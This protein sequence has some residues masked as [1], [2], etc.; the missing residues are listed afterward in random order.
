MSCRTSAEYFM[1]YL[2]HLSPV[3]LYDF[4]VFKIAGHIVPFVGVFDMVV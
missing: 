3:L 2:R 1:T 4:C